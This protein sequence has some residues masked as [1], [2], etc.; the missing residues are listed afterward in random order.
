MKELEDRQKSR[1]TRVKRDS[2]DRALLDLASYYRDVL[3]LQLG[4]DVELINADRSPEL[5]S[6]AAA[7]TPEATLSR[8]DAIMQCRERLGASV[9]PLLAVEAMA[10]ALRTA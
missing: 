5:R 10:L 2:L 6:A 4:S 9:N 1:A 3:T 8:L 7:G